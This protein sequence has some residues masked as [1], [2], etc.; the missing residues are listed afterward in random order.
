MQR[1]AIGQRIRLITKHADRDARGII[2][3]LSAA[4]GYFV[5]LDTA[6]DTEPPNFFYAEEVVLES[7]QSPKAHG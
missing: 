5:H 6:S 4:G 1:L 3:A 2:V 7:E